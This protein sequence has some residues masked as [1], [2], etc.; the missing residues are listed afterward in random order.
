MRVE[1]IYSKASL[2]FLDKNRQTL[3]QDQS[4]TLLIKGVK[5]LYKLSIESVDIKAM[6]GEKGVY[7]IRKGNVR[8]VFTIDEN[9]T[10]LAL[11]V[12]A[13]DFRGN[14]YK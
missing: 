8:I 7:R 13:I 11:F 14:A 4:D 10:V 3:S 12:G 1:I 5:K 6:K 2:S 9:G